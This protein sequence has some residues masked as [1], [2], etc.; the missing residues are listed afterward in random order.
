MQSKQNL[1]LF[2]FN[3]NEIHVMHKEQVKKKHLHFD[4]VKCTCIE[5]QKWLHRVKSCD[6]S[7]HT[8]YVLIYCIQGSF[9]PYVIF[10]LFAS[11]RI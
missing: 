4:W 2:F 6:R 1:C 10:A 8:S 5:C 9:C 11:E 3:V 7:S